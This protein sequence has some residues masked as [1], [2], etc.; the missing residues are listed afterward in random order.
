MFSLKK[1]ARKGLKQTTIYRKHTTSP[2]PNLNTHTQGHTHHALLRCPENMFGLV[3]M[4][5]HWIYLNVHME[6]AYSIEC[7]F[8]ITATNATTAKGSL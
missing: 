7:L 2:F 4:Y 6:T 1:I 5:F 3:M 8:Y